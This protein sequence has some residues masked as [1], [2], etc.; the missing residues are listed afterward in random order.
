M[1]V[2]HSVL[3]IFTV[4]LLQGC[5]GTIP[6]GP[7]KFAA[8]FRYYTEGAL[9]F[10]ALFQYYTEGALQVVNLF[11]YYTEAMLQAAG[12]KKGLCDDSQSPFLLTFNLFLLVNRERVREVLLVYASV[13]VWCVAHFYVY[14]AAILQSLVCEVIFGVWLAVERHVFDV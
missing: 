12:R 13:F 6:K 14:L 4:A 11:R 5:F 8:L 10:A 7:R 1:F 3:S 2:T 9:Q